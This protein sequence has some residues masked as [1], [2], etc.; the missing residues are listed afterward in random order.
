MFAVLVTKAIIFA[1]DPLKYF[2]VSSLIF[3]ALISLMY[4]NNKNYTKLNSLLQ[5]SLQ[6]NILFFF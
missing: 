5:F 4:I 3:H 2:E 1:Y 6:E